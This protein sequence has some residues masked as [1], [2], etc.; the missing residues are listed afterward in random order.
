[1]R[2]CAAYDFTSHLICTVAFPRP[3]RGTGMKSPSMGFPSTRIRACLP[4]R[5]WISKFVP[6][7]GRT[8]RT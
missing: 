1:M 7:N 4:R 5:T 2:P 6:R 3:F 8:K